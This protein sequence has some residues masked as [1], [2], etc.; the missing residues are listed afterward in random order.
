MRVTSNSRRGKAR[1]YAVSPSV[2]HVRVRELD[3]EIGLLPMEVIA[4]P[5][6]PSEHVSGVQLT[7]T[8]WPPKFGPV[9]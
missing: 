4:R 1:L 3:F 8:R 5:C 9:N 7:A 2:Y 6:P